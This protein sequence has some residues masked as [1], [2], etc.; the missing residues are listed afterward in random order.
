MSTGGAMARLKTM[1]SRSATFQTL[2][3]NSGNEAAAADL[4]FLEIAD[5]TE[6]PRD[7]NLQLEYGYALI[8]SADEDER[9]ESVAGGTSDVFDHGG[10]LQLELVSPRAGE[11]DAAD[12]LAFRSVVDDILSEVLAQSSQD[13]ALR[14]RNMSKPLGP[15]AEPEEAVNDMGRYYFVD[16]TVS[17]GSV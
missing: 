8:T 2:S 9:A 3:G 10:D 17:W 6:L 11:N 13:G 12:A 16:L 7:G 5:A 1:V 4:V 15:Y 14:V